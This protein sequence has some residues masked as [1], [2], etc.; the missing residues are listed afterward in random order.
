MQKP[1]DRPDKE[2]DADVEIGVRDS[3]PASDPNSVT[4]TQGPRAVQADQGDAEGPEVR[5]AVTLSRRF[6]DHEAAKLALESLVRSVPLDRHA[7]ALDGSLLKLR[8][9]RAD[10]GRIEGLLNAA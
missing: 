4:S 6:A 9:P 8:V 10:A 3:F 2:A 7:T 1:S 5:D